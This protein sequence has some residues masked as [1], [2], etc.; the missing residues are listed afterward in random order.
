MVTNTVTGWI[1][2]S[3]LLALGLVAA[4][5]DIRHRQVPNWLVLPALLSGLV[6][7]TVSGGWGGL[8][9]ALGGTAMCGGIFVIMYMLGGMGGGDVKLIAAAGALAGWPGAVN[10]LVYSV[11]A[12][13][14]MAVGVLLLR[15]RLFRTLR[16]MLSLKTYSDAL[17]AA[18]MEDEEE[19]PPGAA[20]H[21]Y[22]PYAPAIAAG[23]MLAIIL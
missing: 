18:D 17:K 1:T 13:G 9:G 11:L 19:L 8:L 5:T 12:G 7:G 20:D 14:V 3:V 15:G 4:Y 21:V 10:V 16:G 6:L 23:I 2:V 22:I